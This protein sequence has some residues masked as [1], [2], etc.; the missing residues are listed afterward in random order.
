MRKMR[1]KTKF[2]IF[3]YLLIAAAT[4]VGIMA[5]MGMFSTECAHANTSVIGAKSP[6]CVDAGVAGAVVC[7]DCGETIT[8]AYVLEALGHDLKV[9]PAVAPTCHSVGYTEGSECNRCFLQVSKRA[10]IDM[11]PHTPVPSEDK[12]ATCTEPGSVGGTHCSVCYATIE[13]PAVIPA[14]NNGQGHTWVS[15]EAVESTCAVAG[16]GAYKVC[17][18][19]ATVEGDPTL[20]PL[21]DCLEEDI[22]VLAGTPATCSHT[23]WTDGAKCQRCDK[24]HV[25]Q[26]RTPINPDAHEYDY[27]NPYT[28]AV[29][30]DCGTETDGLTE[31]YECLYCD[32]ILEA[33]IVEWEHTAGEWSVNIEATT[34]AAGENIS[35][36]LDCHKPMFETVNKLPVL[37]PDDATEEEI[38]NKF[39]EDNGIDPD[40]V[41]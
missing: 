7:D 17:S 40:G 29:P 26:E 18:I 25:A 20:L 10:Q 8:E 37:L 13:Q 32:F 14:L 23:G 22:I 4:V 11:L 28:A 1:F 41:V 3:L 19:C 15:Y 21:T 6:T 27:E 5:G 34:E 38:E 2:Y 31:S 35:Y 12:P 9:M 30:A 39:N 16:H 36:C 33:E 24:I